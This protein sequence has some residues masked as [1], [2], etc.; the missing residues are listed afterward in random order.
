MVIQKILG[1]EEN[2]R[3]VN[4]DDIG[5]YGSIGC[6]ACDCCVGRFESMIMAYTF[7]L[8]WCHPSVEAILVLFYV[9]SL[10]NDL[11]SGGFKFLMFHPF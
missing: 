10:K 4:Y 2:D 9:R 3:A 11:S 5:K 1:E 7:Y 8:Q 6:V